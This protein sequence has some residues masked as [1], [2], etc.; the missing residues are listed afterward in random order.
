MS[1][2]LRVATWNVHGLRAGVE[3]VA[4]VVRGERVDILLLQESGPRGRLRALGATLG[5]VVCADPPAFPRRRIQNAVLVRPPREVR[6]HR[7]VRFDG[8]SLI[9]PRGALMARFD[10]VTTFS[11]HLGLESAERARHVP[12]LL[13]IVRDVK[14]PAVV[15]GD[16]NV[17]P[18]DAS[19]ARIAASY[20]DVW[21]GVG[22]GGGST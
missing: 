10:D 22:E 20:P 14:Q 17:R 3:A 1:P 9:H 8:G 19:P 11:V 21:T 5:M 13:E 16:L 4:R 18:E 2:Q 15:A 7:L 6:S 12:Q